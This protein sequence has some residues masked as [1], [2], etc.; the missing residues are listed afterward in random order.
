VTRTPGFAFGR[1]IALGLALAFALAWGAPAGAIPPAGANAA[2]KPPA[3]LARLFPSEAEVVVDRAGLSRLVLPPEVLTACRPDLSDLRLFDASGRETPFLIDSG[4]APGES[5]EAQRRFTPRLLD[6][7]RNE[8][9]REGAPPLRRETFDL[10][11][12]GES[13]A[14]AAAAA[15]AATPG[16]WTLVA[17]VRAVEFV[18]RVRVEQVRADGGVTVLLDG[19][20]L[21]RLAGPR[22]AEKTRLPLPPL[23]TGGGPAALLRVVVETEQGGWLAPSFTMESTRLFERGGRVAVPLTVLTTTSADGRT[24]V[25]VDR[26]RG[27]VPDMVR[28]ETS[29][30]TFDRRVEVHDEG[31]TSLG[32]ALGSGS[33]FRVA[34]LV[35]VGDQEVPVRAV[36][37]GDRLRIAIDDGDSPPLA[38]LA[39]AAVVRQPS[40]IFALPPA[41]SGGTTNGGSTS[42]GVLRFGGGRA[43][44]ARYD[45]SGLLPPPDSAATGRRA[46]AAMLL[47]DPAVVHAARLS[48]VRPNPAY[49]RTPALAFAMHP[50]AT[51][52]AAGFSHTRRLTVPDAPEGLS[53]LRLT[54]EDLAVLRD[55]LADLRVADESSR[56]WP[57]LLD[58]DAATDLAPLSVTGPRAERERHSSY[59]LIPRAAPLRVERIVLEADGGFFD[60]GFVLE[61]RVAGGGAETLARGR[62][63]RP[64]GERR[65]VTVDLR[66]ARVVSL[67]LTID[68]GDDAPLAIRSARARVTLPEIYLTA[69]AGRYLL[70]MGGGAPE[71]PRYELERVRDV[72]LAVQAAPIAAAAVEANRDFSLRGRLGG[73][74]LRQKLLLWAVLVGAAVVLAGL[75][76]RLAR[77]DTIPGP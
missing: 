33:I 31:P 7:T 36:A 72:V 34:A 29:T 47:Y 41:N 20:S 24:V 19:A 70:L 77:R 75:T 10:S 42:A 54:A 62:I 27:I 67:K 40:L 25:E 49:D 52:D 55:D 73:P 50:G 71:A 48:P 32:A 38:D 12:P 3:D 22:P 18:A 58:R 13:A 61:G 44:P 74:V 59:D 26:P 21:F 35:P 8:T 56:Q 57:Y 1:A 28:V 16:G 5:L 45:L 4:R 64:I 51:L 39:F 53:R 37:R 68:D 60:R 43:H 9:R 63:A 6:A 23:A 46:E 69:P 66:P 2:D 15:P 76:L 30:G 11:L 65:P 14:G 17:D